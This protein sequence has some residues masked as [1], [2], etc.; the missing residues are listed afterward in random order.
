[1]SWA[2]VVRA[3]VVD[4]DVVRMVI[5]LRWFWG[6]YGVG[7]VRATVGWGHG[8]GV[9]RGLRV[10]RALSWREAPTS[11]RLNVLMRYFR[12]GHSRS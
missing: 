5:S 3:R 11:V 10:V 6:V 4:M 1:M 9:Q 12:P 7:R 2:C 8:V